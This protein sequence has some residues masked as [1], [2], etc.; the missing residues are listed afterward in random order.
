[1]NTRS[2]L[3][4]ILALIVPGAGHFYLGRR[5]RAVAFFAIVVLMFVVGLMLE[6]KVYTIR[7]GSFL[8]LLATLGSM[9]AGVMYFVARAIGAPGNIASITYE[10]GTAFTLTAGIMNLLLVLDSFDIAEGRKN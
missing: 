6:G 2:L 1:M 3:A 5:R 4:M 9:G 7:P 8:S 10:Y